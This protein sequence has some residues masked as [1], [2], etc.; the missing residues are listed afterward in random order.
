M[1]FATYVYE[2]EQVI[3][4]HHLNTVFFSSRLT[5]R[6]YEGKLAAAWLMV[7]GVPV[8]GWEGEGE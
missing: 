5:H 1:P 6:L 8:P 2:S 3:D 7:R 4:P